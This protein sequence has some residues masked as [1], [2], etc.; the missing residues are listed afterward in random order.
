MVWIRALPSV[1][2]AAQRRS[3]ASAPAGSV[4][5]GRR[6]RRRLCRG[7]AGAPSLLLVSSG[8]WVPRCCQ[9]LR[10]QHLVPGKGGLC[11]AATSPPPAAAA[12]AAG[13]RTRGTWL[14]S[15]GARGAG[16][17]LPGLAACRPPRCA[18][19]RA[20]GWASPVPPGVGQ[21]GGFCWLR[22]E[23]TQATLAAPCCSPPP[24]RTARQGRPARSLRR[25][26]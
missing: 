18:A 2:Q 23:G 13:R 11:S 3:P 6:G 24:P 1:R 4:P 20:A 14:C 26:G 22:T 21:L 5:L 16:T 10:H 25:A 9:C 17:L 19:R 15:E 12:A 8:S 7:V